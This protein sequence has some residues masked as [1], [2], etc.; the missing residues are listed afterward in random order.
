MKKLI[1]KPVEDDDQK[2]FF[3]NEEQF[4]D[5]VSCQE[6]GTLFA[7][8]GHNNLYTVM[9]MDGDAPWAI[10]YLKGFRTL[11][12]KVLVRDFELYW[13]DNDQML[14]LIDEAYDEAYDV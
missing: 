9:C 12:F 2:V 13:I 5:W 7:E 3:E 11:T 10:C 1:Y 8:D 6:R 4:S 14:H